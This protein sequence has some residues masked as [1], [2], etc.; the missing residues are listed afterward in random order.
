MIISMMSSQVMSA[1]I[2]PLHTHRSKSFSVVRV[3]GES[4]Y[5]RLGQLL[6][7]HKRTVQ[8]CGGQ[9]IVSA[10]AALMQTLDDVRIG[11]V[12]VHFFTVEC[13]SD[14]RDFDKVFF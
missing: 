13:A 7:F 8:N 6:L 2:S 14:M 9:L 11:S 12:C 4:R 10:I 5:I 1:G 3:V